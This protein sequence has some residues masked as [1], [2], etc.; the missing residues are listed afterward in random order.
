[1]KKRRNKP[2]IDTLTH[3][4]D[5]YKEFGLTLYMCIILGFFLK[6][7]IDKKQVYRFA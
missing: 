5:M 2:K 3:L 4:S 7:N 6:L 1:M